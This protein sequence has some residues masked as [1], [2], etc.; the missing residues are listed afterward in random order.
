MAFRMFR[1]RKGGT[2]ELR[3]DREE[4][5]L[6]RNLLDELRAIVD[7]PDVL[8]DDVAG[9]LQPDAIPDDRLAEE[10]FRDLVGDDIRQQ[11][12]T[13]IDSIERVLDA[14][15]G[16][17]GAVAADLDADDV[18]AWMISL[19]HL[20]L[21]VGTAL[22]IEDETQQPDVELGS[23]EGEQYAVYSWLS[24]ALDMLVDASSE[25]VD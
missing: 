2:V 3:L 6:V 9:R 12:L 15:T 25:F 4:V 21:A 17:R 23:S 20:R 24:F 7:R 14:G 8:G 10:E 5:R 19:N 1:P 22:G 13:A 18:E 11:R 16:R